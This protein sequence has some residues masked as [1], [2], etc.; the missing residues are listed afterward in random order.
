MLDDVPDYYYFHTPWFCINYFVVFPL[1]VF[2]G[3]HE[4]FIPLYAGDRQPQWH[5]Q[6]N[7]L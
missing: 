7:F 2:A 3:D 6:N 4:C 5:G 1:F